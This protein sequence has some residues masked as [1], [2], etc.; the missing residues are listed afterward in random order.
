MSES[1]LE[2]AQLKIAGILAE[3][4]INTE[5]L[6]RSIEVVSFD[7]TQMHDDRQQL[8][9][10]VHIVLWPIPGSQWKT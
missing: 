6:V 4:E 9:R 2:Q 7:I 1:A 8:D 10:H 3:L 5:Q